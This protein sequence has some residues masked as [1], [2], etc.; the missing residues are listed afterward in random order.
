LE[1]AVGSYVEE[2]G[3]TLAHAVA[4]H[5]LMCFRCRDPDIS[6]EHV[7]Q[8]PV[9]GPTKA[10]RVGVEDVAHA[11]AEWFKREPEDA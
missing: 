9:E 5:M 3:R 1:E 6:L 7:M 4:E 10:T 8:G 11:V 2:E